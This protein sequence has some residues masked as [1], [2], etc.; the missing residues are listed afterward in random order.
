MANLTQRELKKM[1]P[2]VMDILKESDA[3]IMRYFSRVTSARKPD[4]SEVTVAD[5]AAERLLRGRL[6]G[7]WPADAIFGEEYGGALQRSGRC[8]LVDPID[9]TASY[10]LGMPMFGTLIALIID[11]QPVFGCI[12]L[13]ALHETTYAALGHGCWL[14]RPGGRPRRVHVAKAKSLGEAKVGMTSFKERSWLK[15]RGAREVAELAFK[16]GRQRM[17]GDCV[18][19]PLVCRGVLDAAVDPL[20]KP[21]DVAP[22]VPCIVEAGG[23]ISDLQGQTADMIG[24]GSTVAAS[25]EGLRRQICRAIPRRS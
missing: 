14:V 20:M 12:H 5:K 23:V 15:Q 2:T 3:I 10:V 7:A 1:L 21:W 18:Q 13:P 8:W 17:V 11:G 19:Y 25:N 22:I 16:V 24:L 6:G 9:G 4:G